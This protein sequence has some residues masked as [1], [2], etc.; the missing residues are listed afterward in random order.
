MPLTEGEIIFGEQNPLEGEA[1][2]SWQT[3]SDGS[4][5]V[6]TIAGNADWGGLQLNAINDEGRS[7]VYDFSNEQLRNYTLTENRYEAG[8]Y[9]GLADLQIRGSNTLFAQDDLTPD[10]ENYVS[11]ITR[12]WRY[13]QIREVKNE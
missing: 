11:S 9:P 3:W 13:V 7:A 1:P 8:A 6:P 2:I 12:S 5:S 4:G 10:W